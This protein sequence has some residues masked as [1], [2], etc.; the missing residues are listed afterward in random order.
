MSFCRTMEWFLLER[1]SKD[2]GVQPN[3]TFQS[4]KLIPLGD[5]LN[6]FFPG[7]TDFIFTPFP[8][9]EYVCVWISNIGF[10]ASSHLIPLGNSLN[11]IINEINEIINEMKLILSRMWA[12]FFEFL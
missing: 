2:H 3:S 9:I 1:A 8:S 4:F 11:T 7:I 6:I 12:F 10:C 5:Y